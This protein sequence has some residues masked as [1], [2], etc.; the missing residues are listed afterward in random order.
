MSPTNMDSTLTQHILKFLTLFAVFMERI[1]WAI[2]SLSAQ[3][4]AFSFPVACSIYLRMNENVRMNKIEVLYWNI[5]ETTK[6]YENI[7]FIFIEM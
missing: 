7:L 5:T 6:C 2:A 4:L 3:A 1:E